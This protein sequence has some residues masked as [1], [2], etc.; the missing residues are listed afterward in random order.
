VNLELVVAFVAVGLTTGSLYALLAVSFAVI[1]NVTHVFHLAHGAV[2]AVGGY[3]L[4]VLWDAL[5]LPFPL[6]LV[7]AM[8]G[9]AALGVLMET[10]IYAPLRRAEASHLILFVASAGLF[11]VVEGTLGILFTANIRS[12]AALPHQPVALGPLT[13]SN[14]NLAMLAAWPLIGLTTLWLVG[15]RQGRFLRAA[16]DSAAVS[17]VV[18]IPLP[19][20]FVVAFALGSALAVPAALL[21]GWAQGLTPAMG[22]NAILIASAAV[23][24][25]G[26]RGVLAGAIAALVLGVV[27]SVLVAFIP[28]GWQD[29]VTFALL[30]AALVLRPEGVFG[31]ALPW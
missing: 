8:L 7:G 17:A 21:F 25:G 20:V 18:G 16:G 29:A 23:I 28:A 27:Q 6:A 22:L 14:A 13:L 30:G 5:L 4:F 10:A 19:R 2:F 15:S 1:Y 9:A 11:I 26:T 24:I 31:D 12:Y 3:L